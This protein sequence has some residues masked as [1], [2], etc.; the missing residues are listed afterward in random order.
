MDSTLATTLE[1]NNRI[2][3]SADNHIRPAKEMESSD[4]KQDR[5]HSE[6]LIDL[7]MKS[8]LVHTPQKGD[9]CTY[10]NRRTFGDPQ[11]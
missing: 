3:D 9:F 5:T 1:R 8:E 10:E 7:A 4:S 11:Y 2:L 6:I